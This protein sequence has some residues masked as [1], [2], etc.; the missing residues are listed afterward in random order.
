MI[1]IILLIFAYFL[2]WAHLTF[3]IDDPLSPATNTTRSRLFKRTA[4]QQGTLWG[5]TG[6]LFGEDS[7]SRKHLVSYLYFPREKVGSIQ[8]VVFAELGEDFG[9]F[10]RV[11]P[12]IVSF[13]EKVEEARIGWGLASPRRTHSRSPLKGPPKDALCFSLDFTCHSTHLGFGLCLVLFSLFSSQYLCICTLVWKSG[14]LSS[15]T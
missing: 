4:S 11:S 9:G 2:P 5:V 15:L 10:G 3:T 14:L 12:G 1:F 8:L 6:V 13:S 7:F